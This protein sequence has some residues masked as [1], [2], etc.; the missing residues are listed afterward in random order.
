MNNAGAYMP[1]RRDSTESC[2]SLR[3]SSTESQY[4]IKGDTIREDLA[5][6]ASDVLRRELRTFGDRIELVVCEQLR[7]FLDPRAPEYIEESRTVS[8]RREPQLHTDFSTFGDTSGECH[9]QPL[10]APALSDAWRSK[11]RAEKMREDVAEPLQVEGRGG[12]G[13]VWMASRKRTFTDDPDFSD[14]SDSP[15]ARFYGI[16]SESKLQETGFISTLVASSV[17]AYTMSF[18]VFANS[19]SIGYQTDVMARG[20]LKYPPR[21]CLQL[22]SFFCAVFVVEIV[23]RVLGNG[24]DFFC[25]V[26]NWTNIFDFVVVALQVIDFVMD[27]TT[28]SPV[29]RGGVVGSL[30]LLRTMKLVRLL[31]IARLVNVLT[32]LRMMV[33]SIATSLRS[34]WWSFGL[35]SLGIFIASVGCTQVVT[36]FKLEESQASAPVHELEL[37]YGSVPKS[38]LTL[39]ESIASGLSWDSAMAPLAE[40]IS[41]YMALFYCGYVAI[42]LFVVLNIFTGIFVGTA[43]DRAKDEVLH[44]LMCR[45]QLFFRRADKERRGVMTFETFAGAVGDADLHEYL[46]SIDLHKEEATSLFRL[47]DTDDSNTLDEDEFV[48]GCLRLHG[49][50]KAIDMAAF[51]HDYRQWC[52]LIYAELVAIKTGVQVCFVYADHHG[53]LCTT[54]FF[55]PRLTSEPPGT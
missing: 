31:R 34:M 1:V 39:F 7:S 50:A 54:E 49:A 4:T 18:L 15:R 19:L 20:W 24:R 53:F 13:V 51:M 46:K 47:L 11:F 42:T 12:R 38:M 8:F 29:E 45:L 33:V 6:F 28:Q 36:N 16:D 9:Y 5:R 25:G 35:L 3:M 55:T 44:V 40:H 52:K 32:E 10:V 14:S 30:S 48:S 37:L 17:F 43:L 41:P 2:T 22:E 23:L 27:A 26:S 21:Q